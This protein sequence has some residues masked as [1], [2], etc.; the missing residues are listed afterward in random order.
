MKHRVTIG[1]QIYQPEGFPDDFCEGLRLKTYTYSLENR[2]RMIGPVI[3]IDSSDLRWLTI[4]DF[5]SSEDLP[6][7][8]EFADGWNEEGREIRV[9]RRGN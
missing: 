3:E 7:G 8:V 9:Y 4:G 6:T 1:E 5:K 2:W